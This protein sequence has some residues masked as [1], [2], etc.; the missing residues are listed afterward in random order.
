[1]SFTNISSILVLWI[2]DSRQYSSGYKSLQQTAQRFS[3]I[4][5]SLSI[6]LLNVAMLKFLRYLSDAR[7]SSLFISLGIKESFVSRRLVLTVAV[8]VGLY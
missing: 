7:L 8:H 6:S 4:T 5:L 3:G 2:L 1:M